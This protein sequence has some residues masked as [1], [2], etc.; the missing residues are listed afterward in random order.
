[1]MLRTR[2]LLTTLLPPLLGLFIF[3]SILLKTTLQQQQDLQLQRQSLQLQ[4]YAARLARHTDPLSRSRLL[5]ELI[6]QG[7]VVTAALYTLEGN[8]VDPGIQPVQEVS[9]YQ[10]KSVLLPA[11]QGQPPLQLRV[12]FSQTASQLALYRFWLIF[13]I[14]ILVTLL[15][16]GYLALRFTYQI[17]DPL[18]QMTRA[19]QRFRARD[20]S[21][22]AQSSATGDMLLLQDNLN[23]MA[24]TLSAEIT[25]LEE[26]GDEATEDM[27]RTLEALEEHN[28][29]LDIAR[30]EMV[31]ASKLKNEF[32]NSMNHEIRTSLNSIL[33]FSRLLAKSRMDDNQR[34]HL[35]AL[36]QGAKNLLNIVNNILDHSRLEEKKMRFVNDSFC[37]RDLVED[38]QET[39]SSLAHEKDIE[40]ITLID[41]Q[42]PAQLIGDTLRIRQILTNLIS[43]AIKFSSKGAVTVRAILESREP[44]RVT[45]Q[46]AVSDNG[47]GLSQEQQIRLFRPFQQGNQA[48]TKL[49]GSG[50]GLSICKRL[51]EEMGGRI[52]IDSEPGKG[53]TFWVT[54]SLAIDNQGPLLLSL[55]S[56]IRYRVLEAH[57]NLQLNLSQQ[58]A[59]LGVQIH[60]FRNISDL[61][62]TTFRNICIVDIDHTGAADPKVLLTELAHRHQPTLILARYP[63]TVRVSLSPWPDCFRLQ[64]KP[65]RQKAIY[66]ELLLLS[67]T[68]LAAL[69]SMR[70]MVVDDHEGNR[71]LAQLVLTE[72][73]MRPSTYSDGASA[74]AA[75]KEQRPDLVLM[76]IFMPNMDGKECT[77]HLRTL[78]RPDEH[79]PIH[80]LTA[81]LQK[82]E[83]YRLFEAG[84]DG[85]LL[86]PLDEKLLLDLLSKVAASLAA[87]P[88]ALPVFDEALALKRC[89]GRVAVACEMHD[90][91]RR[92]LIQEIP[93]IRELSQAESR[94]ELLEIVHKLHGG[95]RYCGVPRLEKIAGT[96]EAALKQEPSQ[97][98]ILALI[99]QL[100]AH[101]DEV[102]EAESITAFMS[103]TA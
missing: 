62:D 38:L 64:I 44:E 43:N 11:D 81:E 23:Q 63:E 14:L 33:G 72:M 30:K 3:G 54:L 98:V 46:L 70:V 56:E 26:S 39:L 94:E 34:E 87:R 5:Q 42:L 35:N 40:Q 83:E 28:I 61:S 88:T 20:F 1:M 8:P 51:T 17:T 4:D 22:L 86:K 52:G 49:A 101:A 102:Q 31:K 90:M 55:P 97:D 100:L 19:V 59:E 9:N 18:R 65:L 91:L 68:Q 79:T 36:Q 89:G 103:R 10:Q 2:L 93:L 71:K 69:P 95:T 13:T 77:R 73:G 66:D 82:I 16:S 99:H 29:E 41:S 47:P 75:F 6:Q 15:V 32:F 45:L 85:Y 60:E 24:L 50:L 27:R 58:L 74:I 78:E 12:T 67:G 53:A 80:A 48:A 7:G 57:E 84:L 21:R 76:D 96:V 25:K 37:L 92:Q